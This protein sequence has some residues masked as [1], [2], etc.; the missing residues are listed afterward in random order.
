MPGRT[1]GNRSPPWLSGSRAA[2]DGPLL[3]Y[4]CSE[5]LHIKALIVQR[6][7]IKGFKREEEKIT[8][9][10]IPVPLQT[11]NMRPG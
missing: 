5:P 4:D 6:E 8:L 10:I 9:L 7:V 11:G 3:V 1:V 2:P